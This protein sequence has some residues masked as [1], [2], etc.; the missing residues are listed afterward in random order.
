MRTTASVAT[1]SVFLLLISSACA[2]SRP[3]LA[4]ADLR[5]PPRE[6]KCPHGVKISW[7]GDRQVRQLLGPIFYRLVNESPSLEVVSPF[8]DYDYSLRLTVVPIGEGN[9]SWAVAAASFA[10]GDNLPIEPVSVAI[11]NR[12]DPEAG[13]TDLLTD[14][15][16]E[17]SGCPRYPLPDLSEARGFRIQNESGGLMGLRSA[18][19]SFR[20]K[21]DQFIGEGTISSTVR[22]P[23]AARSTTEIEGLAIPGDVAA[24]FLALLRESSAR[25][26]TYFAL[27]WGHHETSVEIELE[28]S[29]YTVAFFTKSPYSRWGLR[30]RGEEY[31]IDSDVPQRALALLHDYLGEHRLPVP[32]S[33]LHC[34]A[35]FISRHGF[36]ALEEPGQCG[37]EPDKAHRHADYVAEAACSLGLIREANLRG[38][39]LLCEA[40]TR[41]DLF[42]RQSLLY[43][44]LNRPSGSFDMLLPEALQ[45]QIRHENSGC[46][47]G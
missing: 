33:R 36:R 27:S 26:D 29:A 17:H 18:K 6:A 31:V 15:N 20:R 30:V 22:Y 47:R 7:D 35:G 40:L 42:V 34:T 23:E 16:V 3:S 13:L 37:N 41:G 4:P 21:G 14:L 2:K 25:K 12:T 46:F 5:S 11:V 10:R 19:Y 45:F 39:Q 1:L 9:D 28:L 32:R 38:D 8:S 24:A 43:E 44:E